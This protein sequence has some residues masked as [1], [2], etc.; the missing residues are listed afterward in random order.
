MRA[1]APNRNNMIA[2]NFKMDLLFKSDCLEIFYDKENK[3]VETVWFNFAA[4]DEYRA[5]M[6]AYINAISENDVKR[7][8]G[9]YRKAR[10]VNA[11]DEKWTSEVWAPLFMP[12]TIK[13]EK[14]GRVSS[15]DI[16]SEMSW[17]KMKEQMD[18]T[19]LPFDFR[20][21]NDYEKAKAWV[22]S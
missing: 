19:K 4:G 11:E 15:R 22:I 9:D 2:L 20:E 1:T 18:L 5:G 17:S 21:F 7:W 16:F 8:L 10:L 3:L 6:A 13:L 12:L 14:F